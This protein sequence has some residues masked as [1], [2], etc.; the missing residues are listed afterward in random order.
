M[1]DWRP[2]TG[3]RGGVVMDDPT[4]IESHLKEQRRFPPP[5]PFARAANVS[6]MEAYEELCRR[7]RDDRDGFWAEQ[8]RA[9]DWMAPWER[10]VDESA[11]PFV[12]WFV[13]GRLNLSANCLDRHLAAR[14]DRPAIVWEGE[15]GDA[16]TLTYRE[17][18]A[19]VSRPANALRA[20][21]LVTGDRV[22]VYLPMVPELAIA[23]PACARVGLTH[24]VIFG[25]FSAEAIR[26]RVND[27]GCRAIL[28]A[29]G[30]WRRGKVVP[31]KDN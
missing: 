29:D 18:H 31:L 1:Q 20:L 16:R 3:E 24:S 22:A 12:K 5:E 11:A 28:T 7:A 6:S 27:A 14:G 26:D 19:A 25:G 10:V 30:G 23:L 9:L 13:G 4:S 2:P 8:A 21:G 17:L 15:P